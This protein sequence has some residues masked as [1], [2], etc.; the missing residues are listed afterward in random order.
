[1]SETLTPTHPSVEGKVR[2]TWPV[3]GARR[4]P[5]GPALNVRELVE[6]AQAGGKDGAD[7]FGLIYDHYFDTVYKFVYFRVRNHYLAEDLTS[8]TFLRAL[9]RINTFTW[10]G[11]DIGAWLITIAR[12]LV[13]DH[14]RSGRNRLELTVGSILDAYVDKDE[15]RM[16]PSPEVSVV[17]YISNVALL[18]A[19][20]K[21]N[22]EQQE[23]LVL[24]FIQGY[25]A[26]E[27]ARL[28]GKNEGAIKSLQ[29]RAIRGLARTLPK[30][31]MPWFR[32]ST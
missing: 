29:Y 16:V 26:A 23:C 17:D 13:A 20:K 18:T 1:V 2:A 25:T 10:F 30:E 21:L 24:R 22:P 11:R 31:F 27:T 3:R 6:R 14:F 32:Q 7:A 28:M 4:A 19:V 12:N 9:A 8:E 5:A 15:D